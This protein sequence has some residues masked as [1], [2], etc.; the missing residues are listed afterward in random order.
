MTNHSASIFSIATGS[1]EPI[2]LQ[3]V[4]QV[5]RLIA[6]GYLVHGDAMPS[7]RDIARTLALNPLTVSKAYS[8]LERD[9]LLER[10]RGLGMWIADIGTHDMSTRTDLLRPI[11]ERAA[12]EAAQLEINNK[13]ALHLFET[14]LKG[15][16]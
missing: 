6:G 8:L 3:I 2:Y 15:H 12:V 16:Q 13:T 1:T 11:L 7:V 5:R 9:G 4:S 10:R 14:I